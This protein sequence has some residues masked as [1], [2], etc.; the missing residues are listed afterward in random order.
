[1]EEHP[2]L[3]VEK[4]QYIQAVISG[5][6]EYTTDDHGQTIGSDRKITTVDIY[7]LL[8]EMKYSIDPSMISYMVER[9]ESHMNDTHNPHHTGWDDLSTDII[10]VLR[11]EYIKHYG[12]VSLS[13]FIDLLFQYVEIATDDEALSGASE[14]KAISVGSFKRLLHD[15]D[16]SIYA[17]RELIEPLFGGDPIEFPNTIFVDP[18]LNNTKIGMYV[19]HDT[20]ITYVS[21]RGYIATMQPHVLESDYS[22]GY[23][24]FFVSEERTNYV[25]ESES[26]NNDLLSV[27]GGATVKEF[28][29]RFIYNEPKKF[30]GHIT[31]SSSENWSGAQLQF[32]Q[33]SAKPYTCSVFVKGINTNSCAITLESLIGD[34]TVLK[35]ASGVVNLATGA[36]NKTKHTSYGE[37]V[38]C[39]I[40]TVKLSNGVMR[41]GICISAFD[42]AEKYR[43]KVSFCNEETHDMHVTP[44]GRE[45]YV[46]GWQVEEGYGMTQYIPTHGAVE[47]RGAVSIDVVADKNNI[48]P[49]AGMLGVSG[50]NASP[51]MDTNK[52]TLVALSRKNYHLRYIDP[53]DVGD[54]QLM[55]HVAYTES[56]YDVDIDSDYGDLVDGP[57][58]DSDQGTYLEAITTQVHEVYPQKELNL[59]TD[60]S[61]GSTISIDMQSTLNGRVCTCRCSDNAG[62]TMDTYDYPQP[63]S[64]MMGYSVGYGDHKDHYLKYHAC[65][66]RGEEREKPY[67]KMI[68]QSPNILHVGHN[69]YGDSVFNGYIKNCIYY[70]NNGTLENI[71]FLS[72]GEDEPSA[73]YTHVYLT[74]DSE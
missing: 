70:P 1:M 17:H 21:K 49:S 8:K 15:H 62:S 6:D 41:I 27:F 63:S 10:S 31:E 47:T 30:Y 65:G 74:E 22:L 12:D 16:T 5:F 36:V 18:I 73:T 44:N 71:I 33:R 60:L 66:Q 26:K 4:A 9:I 54:P 67:K 59:T 48:N 13:H 19:R 56:E 20:P 68:L 29:D 23:P 38:P 25:E 51:Y 11:K 3:D 28:T 72:A 24:T 43:F 7:N 42:V 2:K 64:S 39:E 32:N 14:T 69:G 46:S 34:Q 58:I 35:Y 55:T 61:E 52:R 57:K 37:I 50:L 45:L 53:E 40:S